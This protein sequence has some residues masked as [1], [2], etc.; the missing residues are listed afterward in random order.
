[1]KITE[2]LKDSEYKLELFNKESIENLE[3]RIIT[4]ESNG[5]GVE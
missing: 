4:K 3:K 5:G 2:I 1:M